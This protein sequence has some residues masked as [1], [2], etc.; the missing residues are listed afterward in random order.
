MNK[1]RRKQA[2]LSGRRTEYLAALWLRLKGYK[3]LAR[4]FKTP[5]GELDI[6]A[7]KGNILAII[8]VKRR[9]TIDQARAALHAANLSRIEEAAYFYQS[10]NPALTDLDIRFDGVYVG[11]GLRLQHEKDA[12]RRF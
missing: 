2:E 4:R 1:K 11:R 7:R 5:F 9:K 10:K 3:I 12:W 6:V 8:E